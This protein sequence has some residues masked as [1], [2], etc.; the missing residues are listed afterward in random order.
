[1]T[2]RA[3]TTGRLFRG[4]ILTAFAGIFVFPWFVPTTKPVFSASYAYGFSNLTSCGVFLLLLLTLYAVQRGNGPDPSITCNRLAAILFETTPVSRSKGFYVTVAII[5]TATCAL[6]IAWYQLLPF[7]RFEELPFISSRLDLMVLGYKPYRDFQ[8]NY[9][10]ALLYPPYWLYKFSGGKISIDDAYGISLVVHWLSGNLL[11]C[12]IVRALN[13]DLNRIP[14]YFAIWMA[15]LNLSM[16]VGYTPLRYLGT[17]ASLLFLH[18]LFT[19]HIREQT[20]SI[21]TVAVLCLLLPLMTL[22]VSPEIGISTVVG[23]TGY[24]ASLLFSPL[25]R[26]APLAVIPLI[27]LGV[28]ILVFS[29]DYIE[30]VFSFGSGGNCF[31]VLPTL[32]ILFFIIAGCVVLPSLG[33]LAE[34][35]RNQ[36]GALAAALLL[37]CCL[38]IPAALG[39]CDQLHVFFNGINVFILFLAIAA[40]HPS[41]RFSVLGAG[42]YLLIFVLPNLLS[43]IDSHRNTLPKLLAIRE[44]VH[45]AQPAN[46][47]LN[48]RIWGAA[49]GVTDRL[50]YSKL[51]P[52]APDLG[53]LLQD[54]RIGLPFIPDEDVERFIK[55]S[56]RY[57]PEYYSGQYVQIFTSKALQ[58]KISDISKME[59]ILVPKD[60]RNYFNDPSVYRDESDKGVLS[61]LIGFPQ[62]FIPDPTNELIYPWKEI[63]TFLSNNFMV[64]GEFREYLL[65]RRI[66]KGRQ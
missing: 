58:R 55:L 59:V 35:E 9:G 41:R 52:F 65:M 53:A 7:S 2:D 28:A 46:S 36:N 56:G 45:K 1:V 5:T 31:P 8:F 57:I 39:R 6:Q 19:K 15:A 18:G 62:K 48:S 63:S 30:S 21:H 14:V 32:P 33:L 40:C 54:E 23:I 26:Y 16:G 10:P 66:D 61:Q 24:F 47:E 11:L 38:L 12:Y 43:L 44:S 49:S 22:S 34:R 29:A 51:Y 64:I 50:V 13:I 17:L 42:S 3:Q 27:S 37:S 25:R 20:V 4:I 60:F